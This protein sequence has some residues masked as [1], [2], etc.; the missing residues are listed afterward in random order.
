[1]FLPDLGLDEPFTMV[2]KGISD[3]IIDVE[4]IPNII[5]RKIPANEPAITG[6]TGLSG[7]SLY[8]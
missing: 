1:M 6:C 5:I 2:T 3:F 4:Y 7:M 8:Y